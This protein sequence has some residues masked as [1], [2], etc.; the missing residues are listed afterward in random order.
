MRRE[1]NILLVLEYDGTE[2][3]GW[4]VQVQR[5]TV[6]Q[7]LQDILKKILNEEVKIVGAGRTD[8]GV[9]AKGQVCNFKT[10]S[11]ISV[12]ALKKALNSL[13]PKDIFIKEVKDCPPDFHA[14]YSAKSKLYEYRILNSKERD[15]FLRRYVWHIPYPLN[16]REMARCLNILK[17][18][19]DFSSF[20]SSGSSQKNPVRNMLRSELIPSSNGIIRM[21][22]EA[23][24]F[25]RHM[26]RNIVGTVVDV[27]R[28]RLT[29]EDFLDIFHSKDRKKA[30]IKAPP[31]GLYLIEVRY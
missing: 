14:R 16:L 19:H 5:P 20:R 30:G 18:R 25:L 4:Q 3:L 23:D 28:G 9:H 12:E 13:L 24:G 2:Y 21:L 10:T 6:Q 11:G 26:V 27:G 31:Q 22:F 29:Y 7:V 15:V 8:S 17:G 1:K